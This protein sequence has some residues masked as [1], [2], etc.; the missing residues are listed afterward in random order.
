MLGQKLPNHAGPDSVNVLPALLGES[1]IGRAV[2]VEQARSIAIRKGRWKLI[3]PIAGSAVDSNAKS[4]KDLAPLP[5]LFNLAED[6]GESKNLAK[7]FPEKVAE[8]TNLLD[9]VR[10]SGR[11]P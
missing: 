6:L 10:T 11:L 2:L 7:R 1:K 9:E 8:L 4:E 3:E 5:M